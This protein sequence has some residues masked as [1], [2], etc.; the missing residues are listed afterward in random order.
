[1][2]AQIH[3]RPGGPIVT[4]PQ[5]LPISVLTLR[6]DDE[7]RLHQEPPPQNPDIDS[8]LQQFPGAWAET[9]GMG[10][11]KHRPETEQAFQQ[12]KTALLSAPAL[13]LPDVSKP[14]HL[15]IDENKGIAKAVLTQSLGPWP[16]PV[17]YLSKRLDPVAAGWPP[18]LRMIAATALMVKDADKLTLGQEL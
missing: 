1:M 7:Y 6:L 3:F 17:A 14:F 16:R 9:G 13:G 12:I 10:L 8:W 5:E 2:G 18:C 11:A 15:F 4:G